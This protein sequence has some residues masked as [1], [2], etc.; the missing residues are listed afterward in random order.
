MK[1]SNLEIEKINDEHY[2]VVSREDSMIVA[3]VFYSFDGGGWYYK[4]PGC[5]DKWVGQD[6]Y[7]DKANGL[8]VRVQFDQ[9]ANLFIPVFR[10]IDGDRAWFHVGADLKVRILPEFSRPG[11]YSVVCQY[12]RPLEVACVNN[13][14]V[15]LRSAGL[16]S[17]YNLA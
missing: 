1:Q 14:E 13:F 5:P 3:Q 6:G 9:V 11:Y 10:E 2:D 8:T 17:T 16:R 15:A 7:T 4:R 12:P